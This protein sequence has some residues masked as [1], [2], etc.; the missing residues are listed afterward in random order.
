MD[1]AGGSVRLAL[2][3]A[4]LAGRCS[5]S[6]WIP[7]AVLTAALVIKL[8]T[9]IRLWQDPMLREIGAV[10]RAPRHPARVEAVCLRASVPAGSVP[11][12]E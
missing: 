5:V 6:F 9:V 2:D 8:S 12:H 4:V 1:S 7:A 3:P 11:V 10:S